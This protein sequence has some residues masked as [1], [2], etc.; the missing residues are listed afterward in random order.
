LFEEID[1][2]ELNDWLASEDAAGF[3]PLVTI[4]KWRG[5]TPKK[6]HL[7]LQYKTG[8]H[9]NMPYADDPPDDEMIT[10]LD[11]KGWR[12][13]TEGIMFY[14]KLVCPKCGYVPFE[15]CA[16]GIKHEKC[17]SEITEQVQ[18]A[19]WIY[20]HKDLVFF[21]R[22]TEEK[23]KDALRCEMAKI[24]GNYQE[25][26]LSFKVPRKMSCK[27]AALV[28]NREEVT[29]LNWLTRKCGKPQKQRLE[30]HD[31]LVWIYRGPTIYHLF[32]SP[33]HYSKD[34]PEQ[35]LVNID[36]NTIEISTERWVAEPLISPPEKLLME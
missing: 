16:E 32:Y 6:A 27:T 24:S 29:V 8:D 15:E 18:G 31:L 2:D 36:G 10:L 1:E 35:Y 26:K 7:L 5:K 30:S 23:V 19:K 22:V 11:K 25:I 12:T 20:G 3:T 28:C 17:G 9:H 4:T 33:T 21:G 13:E 34:T 14:N